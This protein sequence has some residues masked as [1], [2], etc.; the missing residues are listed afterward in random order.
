MAL[1]LS[2]LPLPPKTSVHT[3][4]MAG[5][6]VD[7]Y[8][9]ADLPPTATHVSCLWLHHPRTRSKEYMADIAAR[10]VGAWN[11]RLLGSSRGVDGD[12]DGGSDG[13]IGGERGLIAL[14]YDQRN[15]G[16][17]VVDEKANGAWR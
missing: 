6:P 8:G 15:H 3:L 17:R 2:T 4:Q 7:V 1:D 10:C 12:G 5:L 9:L 14:A 11:A 16:G 13:E